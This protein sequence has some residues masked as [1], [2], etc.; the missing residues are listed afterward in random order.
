MRPMIGICVLAA[1]LL[2]AGCG[3]SGLTAGELGE[4]Y[5]NYKSTSEDNVVNCLVYLAGHGDIQGDVEGE[6][7]GRYAQ[8]ALY[9]LGEIHGRRVLLDGG[10]P[11]CPRRPNPLWPV[12]RSILHA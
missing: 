1:A 5:C 2:T 4:R 3:D 6:L 12:R 11:L 9:A 8:A 10:C 7:R